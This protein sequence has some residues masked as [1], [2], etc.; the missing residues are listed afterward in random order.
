MMMFKTWMLSD[1]I[2]LRKTRIIY[3][4]SQLAWY[5][6]FWNNLINNQVQNNVGAQMQLAIEYIRVQLLSITCNFLSGIIW[7]CKLK[8]STAG[9]ILSTD[10]WTVKCLDYTIQLFCQFGSAFG[11][12]SLF[13]FLT[14]KTLSI[15]EVIF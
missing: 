15:T 9:M 6:L 12:V 10:I 5:I 14:S 13:P 1:T 2:I 7:V 3:Y 8:A 11:F 4:W